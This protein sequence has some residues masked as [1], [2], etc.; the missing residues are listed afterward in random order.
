[1]GRKGGREEKQGQQRV[2][3]Q[4]EKTR[5]QRQEQ[6]TR[7]TKGQAD[8]QMGTGLQTERTEKEETENRAVR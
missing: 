8:R 1:M 2:G 6:D 5:L 3:G 4:R 7:V